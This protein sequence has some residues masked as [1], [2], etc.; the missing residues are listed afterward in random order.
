MKPNAKTLTSESAPRA[1]NPH[2]HLY[3]GIL[4]TDDAL[5]RSKGAG[6]VDFYRALVAD[7]AVFSL[8][9]IHI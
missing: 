2:E 9:L 8:S 4:P 7:D 3:M 6:D 5:L 1:K